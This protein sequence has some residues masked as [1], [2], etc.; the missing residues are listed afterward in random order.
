MSELAWESP[1]R[2]GA[3]E[4]ERFYQK[5]L[6]RGLSVALILH[7]FGVGTYWGVV[8]LGQEDEPIVTVRIMKYSELGPPPSITQSAPAIAV[9]AAAVKPSVGIPIPVP[10]AEVNPEQTIA[11][12]QEL[13]EA[14]GPITEGPGGE[15]VI[16]IEEGPP[17]DFVPFEKAP[18][19]IKIV[20]PKYPELAQR[21]G[22]EGTVWVKIWVDKEGKPR[23]AL[24][25]KSTAELFNQAA[26]DAAMKWVFTPALMR[27]GP[28]SVWVSIPFKFMLSKK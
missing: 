27:N 19:A 11:T 2:Y 6:L 20:E 4:L 23:K 26:V 12:Q 3:P 21:A 15:T 17:P 24:V 28:V 25:L 18:V 5:Y 9:S 8:Y 13:S 7:L 22:V 10:D 14:V 16:Q 1:K